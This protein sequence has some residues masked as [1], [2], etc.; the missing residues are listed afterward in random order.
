MAGT[1]QP[2]QANKQKETKYMMMDILPHVVAQASAVVTDP[3]TTTAATKF[4][5]PT[6]ALGVAGLGSGIGVGMVG[7]KAAEAVGRNPGAF[8]NILVI[9]IIGMALAEAIAIYALIAFFLYR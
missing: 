5:G 8:G 4:L 7:A 3:A 1:Q 9:S 2:P 6:F